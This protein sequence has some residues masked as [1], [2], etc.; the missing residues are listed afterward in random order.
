[1]MIANKV[2]NINNDSGN[3]GKM[4][5]AMTMKMTKTIMVI[6]RNEK[7]HNKGNKTKMK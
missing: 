7:D 4:V 5:M 2:G 1:M 3:K 6:K